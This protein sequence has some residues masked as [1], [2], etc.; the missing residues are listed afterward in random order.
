[1]KKNICVFC[2]ASDSVDSRHFVLAERCGQ[3]LA[4]NNYDLVYGGSSRGMMGR[5]AKSAS[6]YGCKV[7]GVFPMGILDEREMFNNDLDEPVIVNNMY[8][9]KDIMIKK[10]DGFLI[11]PG[12]LGTLDE[13]FEVVT[14][15]NLDAHNKAIVIVNFEGF[16]DS[17]ITLMKMVY[18]TG[19]ASHYDQKNVIV[20]DSIEEGIKQMDALLHSS[21]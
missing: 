15:K 8:E 21:P 5:L 19:F 20:V 14:L 17:L 16:W 9:R 18:D 4:E 7:T 2:G 3:L 1:M 13:L 12:G 11:L 6:F 10:S